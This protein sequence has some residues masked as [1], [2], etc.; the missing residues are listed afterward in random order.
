MTPDMAVAQSS[1]L[2]ARPADLLKGNRFVVVLYSLASL[3]SGLCEAVI[4]TLFARIALLASGASANTLALPVVGQLA[5]NEAFLVAIAAVLA[6]MATSAASAWALAA[7]TFNLTRSI[8]GELAGSY[9]RASYVTQDSFGAG[10]LQQTIMGFPGRATSLVQGIA[11]SSAS[12][13]TMITMLSAAFVSDVTA[14]L[15]LAVVALASTAVVAPF[16]RRIKALSI[17]GVQKQVGLAEALKDLANARLEISVFGVRRQFVARMSD[18]IMEDARIGRRATLLKQLTTP[19]FTTFAY[20]AVIAAL[21]VLVSAES[22]DLWSVAPVILIVIRTIQYAMNVQ[23]GFIIWAEVQPFLEKLSS[24]EQTLR[25]SELAPG[26]VSLSEVDLLR[27]RSV[28]FRYPESA[29]GRGVENISFDVCRGE[30]IGL[31]GPSGGGKSTVLKLMANLL[32]PSGG[33]VEVDGYSVAEVQP[34]VWGSLVGYVPQS[35]GLLSA[36]V[37]ENVLLGRQGFSDAE[38]LRACAAA[39]FA[40]VV[41]LLPEGLDTQLGPKGTLLSGGQ[42][43]RLA[44]ARALLAGPSLLL[45]DEPTSALDSDSEAEVTAA[46]RGLPADVA[47]LIASHRKTI[48]QDCTRVLLVDR[49]TVR[50]VKGQELLNALEE[51]ST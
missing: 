19:I 42:L 14:T 17:T 48:L 20:I 8:R 26:Q 47:V 4:L 6:R 41:G 49:G 7:I 13:L 43:Q 36:S 31:V 34:E 27:V 28:A 1:A 24:T 3:A 9:L 45:L 23:N 29:G 50:D 38:I 32:S 16:R 35:P 39:D 46:I 33:S 15:G 11:T 40:S 51:P 37:R 10:E 2:W 44:I 30:R 5:I 18:L 22:G 25:E 21:A 12:G